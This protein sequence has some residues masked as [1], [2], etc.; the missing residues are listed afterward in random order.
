MADYKDIINHIKIFP[1]GLLKP[2]TPF[3]ENTA[4]SRK[5]Q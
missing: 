1:G 2:I 5:K 4:I 3:R